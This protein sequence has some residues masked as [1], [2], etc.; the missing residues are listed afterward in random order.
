[1]LGVNKGNES[2][3]EIVALMFEANS[4]FKVLNSKIKK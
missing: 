4:I 2:A 1:M 3:N